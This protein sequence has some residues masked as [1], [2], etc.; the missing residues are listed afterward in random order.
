MTELELAQLATSIV[1]V[2]ALI[3]PLVPNNPKNK[4]AKVLSL[5]VHYLAQNKFGHARN[6][7]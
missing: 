2:A 5:I 7:D 1:G 6:R 3:A 4:V